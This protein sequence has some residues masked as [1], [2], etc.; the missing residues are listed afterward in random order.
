MV[1]DIT[2]RDLAP[3]VLPISWKLIDKMSLPEAGETYVY[4]GKAGIRVFM[5][6]EHE[7][8]GDRRWLHVSCSRRDRLPSWEDLRAVKDLFIGRGKEALQILPPE[9]EYVNLHP[10]TLHLWHCIDERII[11]G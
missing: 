3:R 9:E 8:D 10:N 7:D 1:N 6:L 4:Q 5:S 11:P 2:I